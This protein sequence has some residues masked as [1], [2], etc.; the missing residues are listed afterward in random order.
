MV[1][2]EEPGP[3][4]AMEQSDLLPPPV[5]LAL[6]YQPGGRF[7]ATEVLFAFDSHLGRLISQAREPLL[8]QMRLAWWRDTLALPVEKRPRGDPILDRIGAAWAGQ[9][10]ALINLVDGWEELL[11]QPP[12]S[13]DAMRRFA[14]ARGEAWAALATLAGLPA[15][16]FAASQAG[17]RWGMVDLA[18]RVSDADERDRAWAVA[19]SLNCKAVPLARKLRPL[20]VLD[21]LARRAIGRGDPD[22]LGGRGAALA[23]MRLG[24]VGR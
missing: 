18:G 3:R 1:C 24:M 10:P 5:R 21:G 14:S 6:A 2:T 22:L 12:L 13:G 8:A 7:D 4:I 19:E 23:L 11:G 17:E 15:D 16:I 20:A 9:E